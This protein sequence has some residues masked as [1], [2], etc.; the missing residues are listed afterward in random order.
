MDIRHVT[1]LHTLRIFEDK[2][3]LCSSQ[4]HFKHYCTIHF[5]CTPNPQYFFLFVLFCYKTEVGA[6]FWGYLNHPHVFRVLGAP[7]GPSASCPAAEEKEISCT[8]RFCYRVMRRRAALA[9]C[10]DVV[11]PPLLPPE[12][13]AGQPG[14]NFLNQ[15]EHSARGTVARHHP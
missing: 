9:E 3:H 1:L 5:P 13:L 15:T 12:H 11:A 10:P 14:G 6:E 8:V 4:L 7:S 2:K